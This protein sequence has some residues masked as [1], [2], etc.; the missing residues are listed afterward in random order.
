VRDSKGTASRITGSQTDISARKLIE[1]SMA[2]GALH[3]ALTG[4]PNRA[5]F[6]D[7]LAQ[8]LERTKRRPKDSFAILFIDL[9]RFKVVND[10][11]GHAVGD[12]LLI[13]VARRL[14]LCI[15][16]EDTVARLGGDEFGILLTDVNDAG[17]TIRVAE[18]IKIRMAETTV[19]GSVHRSSTASIGITI[20]N[21]KYTQP[22]DMLRDA[23]TAMYRAKALGGDRYRIFDPEMHLKARAL[24]ELEADLKQAVENEEWQVYYQ[25]IISLTSGEI[26]GA[27]ALVRWI[28][29]SRGIIQPD[30]FIPL[31]EET[32]LILPIGAYVLQAACT[33]AKL[34]LDAGH[35]NFWVSVNLSARQFQDQQI[36]K[37]IGQIMHETRLPGRTLRLE[38]TESV[39][40]KDLQYSI[41]LLRQLNDLGIHLS[42]DDFGNGYSSL[43]Y[44]RTFPLNVLKIDRTFIQD[45]EVNKNSAAIVTAIITMGHLLNLEV[46]AE[47]VETESQL[48]FLKS[49]FC[50]EAQGFLFSQPVPAQIMGA[51]LNKKVS[52]PTPAVMGELAKESNQG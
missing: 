37:K 27:E 10:S 52:Y 1:E 25:P 15:R 13:A 36:A 21:G 46:V 35:T 45:L 19:L 2:Y 7:R 50:D 24:L 12:Q 41:K 47:G 49:Q 51:I 29:P 3:D 34:W 40:M 28:H 44:L 26:V 48:T 14:E 6:M 23:D 22:N 11:L 43:G 32:G 38:V 39:A 18:R 30:E 42:L 31:A 33:Q 16:P 9:D 5:L 20:F 4:L 8:M 17:D